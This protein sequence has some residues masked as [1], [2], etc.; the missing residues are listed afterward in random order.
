M[1]RIERYPQQRWHV[2]HGVLADRRIRVIEAGAAHADRYVPPGRHVDVDGAC[3]R[4]VRIER[5][6][7]EKRASSRQLGRLRRLRVGEPGFREG[8][9]VADIRA[10][11]AGEQLADIL[12]ACGTRGKA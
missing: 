10:L 2:S 3:S 12:A 7:V 9:S 8:D 4:G 6:R 5:L 1:E 11:A